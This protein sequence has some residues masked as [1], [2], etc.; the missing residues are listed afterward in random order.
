[1]QP[2]TTALVCFL[3][4]FL[5]D[6]LVYMIGFFFREKI[7]NH[8]WI[9]KKYLTEKKRKKLIYGSHG[10]DVFVSGIFRFTPGFRF[11]WIPHL[12]SDSHS[13]LS[14]HSGQ[15]GCGLIGGSLPSV[16]YL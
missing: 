5:S 11:F 2:A 16:Y 14:I 4:V 13:R 15:W 12:R 1:M 9:R 10:T 7:I 3:A 8:V 6:M